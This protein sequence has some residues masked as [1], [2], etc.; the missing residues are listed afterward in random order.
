MQYTLKDYQV[1]AVRDVITRLSR[2]ARD[3]R[4]DGAL[5]SFALSS[6]TGS[7]RRSSRPP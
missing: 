7:A 1:D 6:T 4:Q 2:C 5:K 3:W